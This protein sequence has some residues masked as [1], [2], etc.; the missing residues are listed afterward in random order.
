MN[1][2]ESAVYLYS[3]QQTLQITVTNLGHP[4]WLNLIISCP[5][6]G[7]RCEII[8]RPLCV[9][10]F[11]T[12]CKKLSI[13]FTFEDIITKF[14]H[15]AQAYKDVSVINKFFPHSESQDGR[16][17]HFFFIF[18]SIFLI[19]W[20]CYSHS[21][22]NFSGEI[23]YYKRLLQKSVFGVCVHMYVQASLVG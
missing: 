14:A 22:P 19:L 23:N 1:K 8:K 21:S 2:F 16:H 13:S 20:P 10:P 12:F 5:P 3:C 18:P 11:V 9:R 6:I 7:S 4:W 15:N 17:R